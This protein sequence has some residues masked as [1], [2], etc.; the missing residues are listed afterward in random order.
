MTRAVGYRA[1]EAATDSRKV[2][3]ASDVYSFGVVLLELLTG[4]SPVREDSVHLVRWV[5]SVVR[6][7][8]TGE[9]FDVE[10]LRYPGIEEEMVAMLQIG[11]R[12][13]VREAAE[14]PRIGEVAKLLEEVRSV[15]TGNSQSGGTSSPVSTPA[16]TPKPD[17]G[18]AGSSSSVVN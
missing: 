6:E 11:M 4:K 5:H 16:L 10:L 12:C 3:Q 13:V 1:P 8:W 14:R 7:E 2:S 18:E 17:V 9:V 15:D